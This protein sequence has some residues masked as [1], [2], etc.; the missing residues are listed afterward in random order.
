MRDLVSM[1][2]QQFLNSSIIA[3][4]IWKKFSLLV[5]KTTIFELL[6]ILRPSQAWK[7][8]KGQIEYLTSA[9]LFGTA[10]TLDVK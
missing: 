5:S 8:N 2:A 6:L 9:S 1:F 3:N 10:L 4:H 7:T